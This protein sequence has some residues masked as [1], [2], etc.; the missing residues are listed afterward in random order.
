MKKL[1]FAHVVFVVNALLGIKRK[2][3]G[4]INYEDIIGLVLFKLKKNV[5]IIVKQIVSYMI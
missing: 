4:I 3:I 1:L 5:K 2:N